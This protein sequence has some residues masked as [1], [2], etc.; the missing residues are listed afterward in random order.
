MRDSR[1]FVV[2]PEP[3]GTFPT[4]ESPYGV[5]DM[6]G[7]MREWVANVFGESSAE[8][9]GRSPSPSPARSAASRRG[10][11]SAR[12]TGVRTRLGALGVARGQFALITGP[13]LGFVAPKTLHRRTTARRV[14]ARGR[15]AFVRSS[16][17][18]TRSR[19][20]ASLLNVRFLE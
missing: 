5:R 1:S 19:A 9:L 20:V 18:E 16:S 13:G 14:T 3:I 7:G 8:D 2:Q 11:W 4:D 10:A 6:A 12:A 15:G 17:G